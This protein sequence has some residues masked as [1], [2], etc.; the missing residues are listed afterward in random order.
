MSSQ[1]E[2]TLAQINLRDLASVLRMVVALENNL[3]DNDADPQNPNF[4]N[5]NDAER[6]IVAWVLHAIRLNPS[7]PL[8]LMTIV[9]L[10]DALHD[11]AGEVEFTTLAGELQR[12]GTNAVLE[13]PRTNY[14]QYAVA[15][16]GNRRPTHTDPHHMQYLRQ[17][18]SL[19]FV[20]DSFTREIDCCIV[21]R[22]FLGP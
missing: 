2:F 14:H 17:T 7:H 5:L 15:V 6:A 9:R 12:L 4:N 8:L 19:S 11:P 20:P 13:D 18:V 3:M 21:S 16:A 22:C 1:Q 10:I